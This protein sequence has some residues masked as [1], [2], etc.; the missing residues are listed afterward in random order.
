LFIEWGKGAGSTIGGY[1]YEYVSEDNIL[2][3]KSAHLHNP[4]AGASLY[5]V[6]NALE[7]LR[8]IFIDFLL[9]ACSVVLS[10]GDRI[11]Y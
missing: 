10:S 2:V 4:A 9:R 7:T 5:L 3:G 6:I 11:R 8:E 1:E